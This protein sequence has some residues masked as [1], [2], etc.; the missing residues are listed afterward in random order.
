MDKEFDIEKVH[1]IMREIINAID[2]SKGQLIDI[3][4]NAREE[5]EQLKNE[6]NHIKEEID[7]VINEVDRLTIKDKMVRNKLAEVSK[8][9]KLHNEED[10]KRAYNTAA[11]VKV[12]LMS[13]TREEQHLKVRRTALELSLKRA[14]KNI[15]NAEHIVH[16]V[17]IAVTYLR[18]EIMSAIDEISNEGMVMGIKVLEAQENERM[19]ISR[20]IH[21]GPAQ[22]IASIVM[23]A[24][25][26]ER[27]ARQDIEKGLK[28]LSELKEQSKKALKEVRSIIHDLRPMSL[29]DLGL[30]ET[31]ETYAMTF[32]EESQ[33]NVNVKTGKII[34]E[35]ESIVK[36]AVYRLVQELLNNI[37]KHAK[38]S[39]VT[40]QLEYGS[41]YL[42]LTVV[43][44]GI[45]FNVASTLEALKK[46]HVSYGLLGIHDRVKQF[47][48]EIHFHSAI[49][50]GTSV[51]I[52]L[53]VNRGV[54]LNE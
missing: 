37:K 15:Q 7:R 51:M 21:D 16:Q 30:N 1:I 45:G 54:I 36:V 47:N 24:D 32:S 22:Q 42:R 12:E 3:V 5:H 49:D 48:G 52:K 10:I 39:E 38:A 35:I 14:L 26:C 6:L 28:E 44:N 50:E 41:K 23:K 11:D 29:D 33:I 4:E 2:K 18:G 27:I 8:S 9:F 34:V 43:D 31:I 40:I 25:F 17:T 20:D 13:A 53:P 46:K 19:R